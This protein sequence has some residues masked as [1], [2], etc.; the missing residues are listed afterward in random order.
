MSPTGM[1]TTHNGN[2][3]SIHNVCP[4]IKLPKIR[5]LVKLKKN[6]LFFTSVLFRQ[7]GNDPL[8]KNFRY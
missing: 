2:A 4:D 5:P 7:K 3:A 6:H 8:I 1:M